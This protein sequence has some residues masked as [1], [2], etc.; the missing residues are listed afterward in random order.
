MKMQLL[1][2]TGLVAFGL[3]IVATSAQAA[4]TG[5]LMAAVDQDAAR[6]NPVENVTWHGWRR[7][8]W[9]YG[10][11]HCWHG[12][13]LWHHKWHRYGYYGHPYRYHYGYHRWWY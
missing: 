3:G 11:R 4:P 1:L 13:G 12:D 7:C 10:H 8:Y 9:H 5:G 2:S 6:T